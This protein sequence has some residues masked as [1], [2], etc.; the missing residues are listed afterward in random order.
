MWN[1][2]F[3]LIRLLLYGAIALLLLTTAH[4]V[5]MLVVVSIILYILFFYV[6]FK[7]EMDPPTF[8]KRSYSP[9]GNLPVLSQEKQE[10]YQ[11]SGLSQRDVQ[12]FRQKMNTVKEQ[13][14]LIEQAIQQS[15]KL[16]ALSNRYNTIVVMKDF[17]KE[18]VHHPQR[19]YEADK[20]LNTFLP[21]LLEISTKY[22][23]ISYHATKTSETFQILESTA[24]IFEQ[25]CE[26]IE[27]AYLAFQTQ[28]FEDVVVEMK[29]IQH[30]TAELDEFEDF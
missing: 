5:G 26:Q 9:E 3:Q 14:K 13:I 7:K 23:D 24:D 29:H 10:L 6:F 1:H 20:F 28:D 11:E 21:S 18:I 2:L 12:F 17:F 30:Q 4:N 8:K 22:L 27:V 15:S 16:Q 19:L 25:L